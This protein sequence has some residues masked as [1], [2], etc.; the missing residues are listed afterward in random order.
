MMREGLPIGI[1]TV[2]RKEPG[3]FAEREIKLLQ[4]FA[5]QA[6]IAIQNVRLFTEIQEKSRQLEIGRAHV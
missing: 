2:S 5:D 1:I 4:T 6:V 3:T